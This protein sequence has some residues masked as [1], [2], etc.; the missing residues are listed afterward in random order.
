M[1]RVATINTDAIF[2]DH[3]KDVHKRKTKGDA[4]EIALIKFFDGIRN[5]EEFREKC[6]KCFSVPFNSTNKWMLT[7]IQAEEDI[8]GNLVL[9]FKGAP[10]KV[11][12]RC[13][14]IILNGKTQPLTPTLVE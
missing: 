13:S 5:I 4:S 12:M 9:L 2:L 8:N 6:P 1:Q 7:I 14:S 3:D 11:L 10:E